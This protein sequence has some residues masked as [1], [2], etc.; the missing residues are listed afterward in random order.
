MLK[1]LV[2]RQ[3]S[4]IHKAVF[5]SFSSISSR[6]MLHNEFNTNGFIIVRNL[7]DHQEIDI[8]R[9]TIETDKIIE[10]VEYTLADNV[11]GKTS[12]I[13]WRYLGNDTFGN[14]LQSKRLLDNYNKD[15][16]EC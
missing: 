10:D 4:V 14:F 11:G 7:F 16:M 1:S 5:R 15:I 12:L 9:E 3:H 13:I 8:L 6:D 2:S